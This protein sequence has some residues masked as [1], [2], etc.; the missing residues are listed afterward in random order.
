MKFLGSFFVMANT[1]DVNHNQDEEN[2]DKKIK[3][4]AIK[5][6]S[7][8]DIRALAF[9]FLYIADS[10]GYAISV[11]EMIE[12]F[13]SGFSVDIPDDSLAI[14]IANSVIGQ[15]KEL[16]KQIEPLLQN[17]KLERLSCCTLLILRMSLWE[18]QQ[19]DAIP[20]VV[21]NEAIELAKCF[22]EKDSYKFI[23]GI[24]DEACKKLNLKLEKKDKKEEK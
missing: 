15:R 21:I 9:H 6:T 24:L 14:T 19:P 3:K 16:D 20:S 5:V 1:N 13:R 22:A 18:I 17:W 4:Y 8:R 7:R 10:Y 23:N 2:L 11:S 12:S